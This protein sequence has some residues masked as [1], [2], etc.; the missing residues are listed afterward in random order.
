VLRRF[1]G[2]ADAW[3]RDRRSQRGLACGCLVHAERRT[4]C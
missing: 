4:F 3:P 2:F 1:E